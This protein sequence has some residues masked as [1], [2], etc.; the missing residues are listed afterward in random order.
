M[1]HTVNPL[2]TE[3]MLR[4]VP[5]INAVLGAKKTLFDALLG[6]PIDY[7]RGRSEEQ[8]EEAEWYEEAWET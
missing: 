7:A 4:K 6:K 1:R 5:N 2:A 8:A 3:H